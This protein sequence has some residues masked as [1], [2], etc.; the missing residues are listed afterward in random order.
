MGGQRGEEQNRE[1]SWQRPEIKHVSPS[2]KSVIR[3]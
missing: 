2:H 1:R 3:I